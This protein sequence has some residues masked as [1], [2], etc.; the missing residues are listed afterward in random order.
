[1]TSKRSSK[2]S[3]RAPL[4]TAS[5][6]DPLADAHADAQT[7][8]DARHNRSAPNA[9][10]APQVFTPTPAVGPNEDG[11]THQVRLAHAM[12]DEER[13]Q[14]TKDLDARDGAQER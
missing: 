8:L 13:T 9:P 7:M 4:A 6:A 1:M 2:S 3:K 11:L 5:A 14:I 10:T 12:T